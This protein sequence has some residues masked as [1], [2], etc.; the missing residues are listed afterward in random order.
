MSKVSKA[1]EANV[2]LMT[3]HDLKLGIERGD[4]AAAVKPV[5]IESFSKGFEGNGLALLASDAD[6]AFAAGR[7]APSTAAAP[8]AAAPKPA[9]AA[10]VECTY[11]EFVGGNS[12]KF[13]RITLSGT[14][15]S[16]T[17]G[18]IGSSGRTPPPKSHDVAAAARKE[19]DEM[20]A[21]KLEKGYAPASG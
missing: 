21:S 6:L 12:S 19:Y 16:V 1:R 18:R 14:T 4:A 3:L 15:T 17:F 13:W 10:G 11:L 9:A 8:K 7:A 5:V 2:T 20:I